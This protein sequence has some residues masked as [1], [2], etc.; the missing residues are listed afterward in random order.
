M[1]GCLICAQKKP[2]KYVVGIPTSQSHTRFMFSGWL[3]AS[4]ASS[5]QACKEATVELYLSQLD[6]T[7]SSMLLTLRTSM[8]RLLHWV[9]TSRMNLRTPSSPSSAGGEI[10]QL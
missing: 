10:H 9:T 3:R 2:F 6:S 4:S 8:D 1:R 7:S 5:S